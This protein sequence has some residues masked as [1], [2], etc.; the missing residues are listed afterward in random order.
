MVEDLAAAILVGW[1]AGPAVAVAVALQAS[2]RA[3]GT[4]AMVAGEE[5]E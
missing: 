2:A 4:S 3:R 1:R 5:V